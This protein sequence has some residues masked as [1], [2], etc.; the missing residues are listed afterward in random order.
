M[1]LISVLHLYVFQICLGLDEW[2]MFLTAL[3]T[4]YHSHSSVFPPRRKRFYF[5]PKLK[6]K[7]FVWSVTVDCWV[8]RLT[9]TCPVIERSFSYYF[10]WTA[11][12]AIRISLLCSCAAVPAASFVDSIKLL[13]Q[14][15]FLCLH[16]R[17]YLASQKV[18]EIKI[19]RNL[20]Q[21]SET[22]SLLYTHTYIIHIFP[23]C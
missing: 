15:L 14:T 12:F 7:S 10:V 2:G 16:C 6:F 9:Y 8:T 20:E 13:N 18:L 19:Y 11:A 5:L 4:T 17:L 3:R 21:K 1:C 23:I 22:T